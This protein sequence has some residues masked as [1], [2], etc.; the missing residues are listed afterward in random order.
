M[1]CR[2]GHYYNR[3][4]VTGAGCLLWGTMTAGFSATQTVQQGYIFWAVNGI[5][6]SLVIPNGQ[7]LTADYF[8]PAQRGKAFG[9]LYLTGAVG[10]TLGALYATNIGD[11]LLFQIA[12]AWHVIAA[13]M[14]PWW[15][16]WFA[17]APSKALSLFPGMISSWLC[18][19]RVYHSRTKAEHSRCA[20]CGHVH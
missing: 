4:W 11:F 6:L 14:H 5:G 3:A 9:G 12:S 2:A 18:P 20:E 15:L 7:S 10:A 1:G 17:D 8:Q 13:R 19:K 16:S